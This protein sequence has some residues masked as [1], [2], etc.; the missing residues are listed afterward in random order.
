MYIIYHH[1]NFLQT[2]RPPVHKYIPGVFFLNAVFLGSLLPVFFVLLDKDRCLVRIPFRKSADWVRYFF[3][4]KEKPFGRGKV[5]HKIADCLEC[6]DTL[7]YCQLGKACVRKIAFHAPGAELA[8][9]YKS[10]KFLLGVG[11]TGS[12]SIRWILYPLKLAIR[13]SF[14]STPGSVTGSPSRSSC[15]PVTT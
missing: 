9:F 4:S 5:W 1:Q 8:R 6:R 15:Q 2:T 11:N 12:S 14:P 13:Q 7:P 3:V 10:K